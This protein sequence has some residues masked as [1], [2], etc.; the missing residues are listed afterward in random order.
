MSI[1]GKRL[2]EIL[3]EDVYKYFIIDINFD[4]DLKTNL[5]KGYFSSA[6]VGD[7]K[8]ILIHKDAALKEIDNIEDFLYFTFI[9]CHELAHC[10]NG[11]I[12][13]ADEDEIDSK[14][15]EAW[16]DYSSTLFGFELL[17][18]GENTS[19]ILK[20]YLGEN[21]KL[22]ELLVHAANTIAEMY[23]T[24][25][26][27]S[28]TNK[29][30][31]PSS[32]F[33]LSING[34]SAFFID[35]FSV[36]SRLLV[37]WLI[38]NN[39]PQEII[40]DVGKYEVTESLDDDK[41][42]KVVLTKKILKIHHKIQNGQSAITNGLLMQNSVFATNYNALSEEERESLRDIMK[43]LYLAEYERIFQK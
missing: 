2:F 8:T 32:R 35:K 13:Y 10:L 30:P 26:G 29:Y 19:K 20:N 39:I 16:A 41:K 38:L 15:I 42:E 17:Y 3:M 25:F 36:E 24:I 33:H 7:K 6:V 5:K 1:S 27:D 11:H 14:A 34:I 21:F 18:Y 12:N 40:V 22:E 28:D 31:L 23:N 9:F 4:V 43:K 37:T